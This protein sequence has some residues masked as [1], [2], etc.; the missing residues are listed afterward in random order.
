MPHDSFAIGN[1]DEHQT[2]A[3]DLGSAHELVTRIARNGAPCFEMCDDIA[4]A[5]VPWRTLAVEAGFGGVLELDSMIFTGLF[6]ESRVSSM[7]PRTIYRLQPPPVDPPLPDLPAPVVLEPANPDPVPA[8]VPPP[9]LPALSTPNRYLYRAFR[10]LGHVGNAAAD[11]LSRTNSA[12][13][14]SVAA[15]GVALRPVINRG[16]SPEAYRRLSGWFRNRGPR[17]R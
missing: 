6:D 2:F 4:K 1:S 11:H 17:T 10:H 16:L 7:L 14:S 8:V 9:V 15:V 12:T 3:G 5:N 13:A